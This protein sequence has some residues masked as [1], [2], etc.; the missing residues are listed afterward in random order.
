MSELT[1]ADRFELLAAEHHKRGDVTDDVSI[2]RWSKYGK[3]RLYL[4]GLKTGDGWISLKTGESGGDRWTKVSADYELEG[5]ELTITVGNNRATYTIVVRVHGDEFEPADDED[6]DEDEPEIACDGGEDDSS[7]IA[8]DEILDAI[9]QHDDPDH[10]DGLDVPEVRTYL[11][12]IQRDIEG[13]WSEHMDAVEDGAVEVVADDGTVVVLADH[14]GHGWGEEF[15]ALDIDDDIAKRVIKSIHH[16]AARRHT[17]YSWSTSDPLVVRKP[18]GA[19]NGQRYVEAVINGF[20][21][22]GLSPG[23]A[24]SVYGVHVAGHSRNAW[25]SMCGYSDHS[26]ISEPLRK[27]EEKAGHLGV[28]H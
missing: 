20:M 23:Q 26:A 27:A 8:D 4:N 6:E 3:D 11:A 24:W 16:T 10:P 13:Y 7:H 28:F 25:A 1:D 18:D 5:D 12:R 15:D 17:D 21:R 14:T 22:E 19:D 2:D 9:D